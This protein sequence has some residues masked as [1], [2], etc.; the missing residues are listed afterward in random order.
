M[1]KYNL[2]NMTSLIII[3]LLA[4]AHL[5]TASTNSTM[6]NSTNSTMT[7]L[8]NSTM[9]NPTNSTKNSC[10][11]NKYC[12]GCEDGKCTSCFSYYREDGLGPRYILSGHCNNKRVKSIT[13]DCKFYKTTSI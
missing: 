1:G 4:T 6:T 9:T 10:E 7:N 8:T 5:A 11:T 2:K 12:Q 3:I 13:Q